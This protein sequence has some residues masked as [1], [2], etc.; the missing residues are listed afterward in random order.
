M[1]EQEDEQ[2]LTWEEVLHSVLFAIHNMKES[3]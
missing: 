2:E 1:P 3:N